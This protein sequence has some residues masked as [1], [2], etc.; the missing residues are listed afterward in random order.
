M[1]GTKLQTHASNHAAGSYQRAGQ[2]ISQLHREVQALV[3]RAEPADAY[4]AKEPLAI[5]AALAHR[6]TRMAALKQA[7]PA[8]EARAKELAVAQ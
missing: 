4:E 8:I 1:A 7:R 2:L 6:E 3:T 5:P